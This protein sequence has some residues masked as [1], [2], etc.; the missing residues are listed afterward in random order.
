MCIR[1]FVCRVCR[2]VCLRPLVTS[3]C[4]RAGANQ[5][6]P[7]AFATAIKNRLAC[8]PPD[9]QDYELAV[10]DSFAKQVAQQLHLEREN[11][12]KKQAL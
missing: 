11:M 1:L 8:A 7:R 10:A 4:A 2:R 6:R 12:F 3:P 5:W 9:R